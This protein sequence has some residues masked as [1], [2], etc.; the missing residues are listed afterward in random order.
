MASTHK[1]KIFLALPL[2]AMVAACGPSYSPDSY[3]SG[4]VGQVSRVERGVVESVRVVDIKH[5]TGVGGLAGAGIGAA[6][7]STVGDG[8][9]GVAGAI[10]GA[11]IGGLIGNSIEKSAKKKQGFEYLI[12]TDDGQLVTIVQGGEPLGINAPVLIL[13]GRTSRVVLDES[14]ISYD[15]GS[16]T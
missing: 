3:E 16:D 2:A 1:T 4:A 14:R 13:Y 5:K 8:A 6:A 7:G 10:G 12:R 11:L 15:T 9:G